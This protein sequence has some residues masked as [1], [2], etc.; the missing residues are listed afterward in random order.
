MRRLRAPLRQLLLLRRPPDH[1]VLQPWRGLL[2]RRLP[3][4]LGLQG[5]QVR[6]CL[7]RRGRGARRALLGPARHAHVPQRGGEGRGTVRQRRQRG[8]PG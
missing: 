3:L 5:L 7:Q 4:R 2:G 8:G 1:Q 6:R